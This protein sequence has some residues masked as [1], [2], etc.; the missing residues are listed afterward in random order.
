MFI[1]GNKMMWTVVLIL[2][3][4]EIQIN[5]KLCIKDG[6]KTIFDECEVR[7]SQNDSLPKIQSR[8]FL[9]RSLLKVGLFKVYRASL[10][11]PIAALKLDF[12]ARS[13]NAQALSP[14][15]WNWPRAARS[16][17]IK[18]PTYRGGGTK[19]SFR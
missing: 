7:S 16:T 13:R 12:Y 6:K 3:T 2:G 11:T 19:N 10:T 1:L 8:D 17:G 18:R 5:S 9:S 14:T 15:A 4:L